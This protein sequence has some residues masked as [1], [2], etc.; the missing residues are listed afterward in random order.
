LLRSLAGSLELSEIGGMRSLGHC[1][2]HE[3][4]MIGQDREHAC[5][6]LC[7][8]I[9]TLR[10]RISRKEELLAGYERD[11]ATLRQVENMTELTS[12]QA[13]TVMTNLQA[14]SDEVQCLRESLRKTREQ[15]E[16]EKKINV[17]IKQKKIYHK[18]DEHVPRNGWPKHQCPPDNSQYPSRRRI[19][20]TDKH[21]KN[22]HRSPHDEVSGRPIM[23]DIDHQIRSYMSLENARSIVTE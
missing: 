8:H 1:P 16:Q 7:D 5:E 6:Q 11:L 15:L 17:A 23:S 3:R 2:K 20:T 21:R 12:R 14:R 18:N 9:R 13:Q 19:P 10:D 4:S 22:D